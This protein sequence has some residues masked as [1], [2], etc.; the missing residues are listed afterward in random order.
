MKTY[1]PSLCVC[2]PARPE[3]LSG[4]RARELEVLRAI[5]DGRWTAI[6]CTA[7]SLHGC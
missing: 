6:S 1:R 2:G 5:R 4:D 7:I 3:S